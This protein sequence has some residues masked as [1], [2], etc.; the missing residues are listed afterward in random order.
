MQKQQGTS[1][2]LIT[3]DLSVVA[4]MADRIYVMYSGKIVE[5]ASAYV[6]FKDPKH[7]YTE[8]LLGAIPKLSDDHH[9]FIQIPDAVPSPMHKPEGCYFH[10]RCRYATE[11][12]RLQMPALASCGEG[13]AVRCHHPL[14]KE[15][16]SER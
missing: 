4:N 3:H 16:A 2:L 15:A 10:P 12:C 8:G 13:R 6:L 1:L 11:E 9:E 5:E 14:N 7:P